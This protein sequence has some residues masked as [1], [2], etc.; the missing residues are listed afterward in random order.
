MCQGKDASVSNVVAESETLCQTFAQSH[1][2][3][4]TQR[5]PINKV[6]SAWRVICVL[7][8]CGTIKACIKVIS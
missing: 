5:D 4:L 6:C 2:S 7:C 8:D 3:L 1:Y